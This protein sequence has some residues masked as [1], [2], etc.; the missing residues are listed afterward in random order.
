MSY[1]FHAVNLS[2]LP[3]DQDPFESNSW[4]DP[5]SDFVPNEV[6]ADELFNDFKYSFYTARPFSRVRSEDPAD[7]QRFLTF[8]EQPDYSDLSEVLKLKNEE[9][10]MFGHQKYDFI[11][12][13]TFNGI[14]C[15]NTYVILRHNFVLKGFKTIGEMSVL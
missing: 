13:C 2:T 3:P 11:L 6:D 5:Y 10:A 4:K 15:R 9:I 12:Q 8:S 14:G 7:W 1:L